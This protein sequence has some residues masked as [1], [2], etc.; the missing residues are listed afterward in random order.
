MR[1][2]YEDGNLSDV[3]NG[4]TLSGTPEV[5]KSTRDGVGRNAHRATFRLIV[6][7]VYTG[8]R[9]VCSECQGYVDGKIHIGDVQPEY[10]HFHGDCGRCG[11]Q[12]EFP[13]GVAVLSHPGVISFFA[14]RGTDV[15]S[16]PFWTLDFCTPR[17]ETEL[18]TNPLRLR[19]DVKRDGETLSLTLNRDG[20][21]VSTER[22]RDS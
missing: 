4:R 1:L 9:G 8:L 14:E 21:V 2:R 10:Y 7:R 13:V 15:R 17:C 18:S 3:W 6:S 5:A 19:V 16:V 12:T 20:S 22:S 11:F